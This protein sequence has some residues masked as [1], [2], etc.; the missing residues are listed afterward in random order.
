MTSMCLDWSL[1]VAVKLL[2]RP[3]ASNRSKIHHS[4]RERVY[5]KEVILEYIST[6]EMVTDCFTKTLR[7]RKFMFCI[8]G[9]GVVNRT[10]SASVLLFSNGL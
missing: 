5:S 4:A 7:M 2:K 8:S 9:M 6:E 1:I 3:I 10:I